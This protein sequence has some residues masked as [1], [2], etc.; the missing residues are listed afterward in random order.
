MLTRL[1]CRF[2][3]IIVIVMTG[4]TKLG[5]P[6]ALL[7]ITGFDLQRTGQLVQYFEP[8]KTILAIQT[9]EQYQNDD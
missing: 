1:S 6:T 4:Q 9:G 3:L 5:L 8:K 7:I 2:S